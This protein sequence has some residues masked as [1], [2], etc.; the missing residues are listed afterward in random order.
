MPAFGCGVSTS[1]L[2]M[3]GKST[4][5][6]MPHDKACMEFGEERAS[7]S[8]NLDRSRSSRNEYHFPEGCG[9]SGGAL[10]NWL[11]EQF[12]D[13]AL[14]YGKTHKPK[15]DGSPRRPPISTT[16]G[17]SIVVT[18]DEE[19]VAQWP[20]WL[21]RK[22]V[23]DSRAVIEEWLGRPLDAYA[24]HV[25]EGAIEE[26]GLT[27]ADELGNDGLHWHGLG[28]MP[29]LIPDRELLV[30]YLGE[31]GAQNFIDRYDGENDGC[32]YR[33]GNVMKAGRLQLLH[34]MFAGKMAERG[35]R[36]PVDEKDFE[37]T[38][39]SVEPHVSSAEKRE[40]EKQG[41]VFPEAGRSANKYAR[42][43]R[44]ERKKK[45]EQKEAED[46]RDT[47]LEAKATAE[48]ERDAAV[49]EKQSAETARD[50]AITAK[51]DA[52]AARDTAVTEKRSAE[53]DA[54]KTRNLIEAMQGDVYLGPGGGPRLGVAG[55]ERTIAAKREEVREQE[56]LRNEARSDA[57]DAKLEARVA[58]AERD[59][60]R[61][62]RDLYAGESYT[63][64]LADGTREKR[65]G[66]AG[67]EKRNDELRDENERLKQANDML[68]AREVGY[69]P[70][71]D[72]QGHES[73]FPLH[74][75]DE[76]R[77][78]L[79]D[80]KT[81]VEAAHQLLAKARTMNPVGTSGRNGITITG[82][83][84]PGY[85]FR[86]AAAD[87]REQQAEQAVSEAKAVVDASRKHD[88]EVEDWW[89]DA[90]RTLKKTAHQLAKDVGRFLG[91]AARKFQSS[92]HPF[93]RETG[94][95]FAKAAR[96][97]YASVSDDDT[98]SFDPTLAQIFDD[99]DHDEWRR[100]E[101]ARPKSLDDELMG[102]FDEMH[103]RKSS[104][105]KARANAQQVQAQRVSFAERWGIDIDDVDTTPSTA[106]YD[107]PDF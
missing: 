60:A 28:R 19:A 12:E 62:I 5:T 78:A 25:D 53:A 4:S 82:E 73:V 65:L 6:S 98:W 57:E 72:A 43:A 85:L 83:F 29:D 49:S 39:W 55:Y 8:E 56:R 68:A 38:G 52:E 100:V 48:S 24:K 105:G 103:G 86:E 97:W 18:P 33:T 54:Q 58:E 104:T 15:K 74:L 27:R 59:K 30:K 102:V 67:L 107:E 91:K 16:I 96:E 89:A 10:S 45:A 23:D 50:A 37:A 20:A 63:V 61:R 9:N 3:T 80:P 2:N 81:R 36:E 92:T 94:S 87:E 11:V 7:L 1:K 32:L 66:L 41:E 88:A 14:E 26:R 47:A 42:Q 77:D 64:T 17:L 35:W 13:Y 71:R 34:K 22:F 84:V 90:K 70:I 46:A 106:D 44:W 69:Y 101:E 51:E 76:S 31:K 75:R 21:R 79:E 40:R 99:D 93:V 95:L